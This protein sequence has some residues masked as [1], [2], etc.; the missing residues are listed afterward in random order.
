MNEPT[1]SPETSPQGI[2]PIVTGIG[3]EHILLSYHYRDVDDV[4]GFCSLLDDQVEVKLAGKPPA[5]GRNA[6]LDW[7]RATAPARHYIQKVIAAGDHIAV[8]GSLVDPDRPARPGPSF[9]EV[10]TI[11]E[12]GLL[13]SL[14]RYYL[15][16]PD[17]HTPRLKGQG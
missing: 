9:A 17:P 1:M 16:P 10:F 5:P 14:S 7:Q 12:H 15:A 2:D 3:V 8:F 13:R 11:S 4:D 6:A